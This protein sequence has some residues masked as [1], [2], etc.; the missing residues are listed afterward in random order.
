MVKKRLA[1]LLALLFA[2]GSLLILNPLCLKAQTKTQETRDTNLKPDAPVR[3]EEN[4]LELTARSAILIDAKSGLVLWKMN[5]QERLAIASLTKIMSMLLI[6]EK[7]EAK[8]VTLEDKITISEHAA[9]MGGTQLF[10]EAGET[11]TLEE[12]LYGTAVESANDAVTALAE[13][14][15]GSLDGFVAMMNQKAA[16]LGLKNTHFMDACGLTDENH[17]STAEDLAIL[18]RE[19]LKHSQA[20][21]YITTWMID[22][23]V[24]KDND[25]TRTLANSN[26]LLKSY[27]GCDGIK[28]GYTEKAG[29][30]LA[31]SATRGTMSLIGIVLGSSSGKERNEDA[32]KLLDYGFGN[33]QNKCVIK[34][35]EELTEINVD[36][37]REQKVKLVAMEDVYMLCKKGEGTE[38]LLQGYDKTIEIKEEEI[39][40]PIEP[41]E[42]LGKVI[43]IGDE[44][45]LEVELTTKERVEKASFLRY[46]L[47]NLRI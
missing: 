31:F 16:N 25:I 18:S 43:Y 5:E 9:G 39:K 2:L 11:R 46:F 13:Y 45:T 4:T 27:E 15:G 28:T 7:L 40:A 34:K 1:L 24:G 14:I 41:G 20:R 38:D 35:G 23:T 42:S 30:C 47:R 32:T 44:T 22:V 12:L 19:F 21:K 36:N 10:L 6:F 17:Y 37:A 33:Y 8:E 3:Q 29:S 26:K